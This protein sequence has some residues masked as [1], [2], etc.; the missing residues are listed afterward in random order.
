[1]T[2]LQVPGVRCQA[3]GI[4]LQRISVKILTDALPILKLDSFLNIFGRWR[5]DAA[6]PAQWVDLADYAHMPNGPGIVLVGKLCNFSFDLGA[7]APGL[8]YAGKKGLAGTTEDRLKAVLLAGFRMSQRLVAE[9]EFPAGIHLLPGSL[10]LIFNDRL[11]TPNNAATD[12]LLRPAVRAVLDRLCGPGA[13]QLTPQPDPG[14]RYGFTVMAPKPA[15][16]E[17]AIARLES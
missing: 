16:V 12:R 3:P 9:E 5:T 17:T 2:E 1:M 8:L 4:D 6:H 10:E 14:R 7:G 15:T 11:E 13:Y